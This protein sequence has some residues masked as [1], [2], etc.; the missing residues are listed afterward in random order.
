ML[1]WLLN[2]FKHD[3]IKPNKA[4]LTQGR[5]RKQGLNSAPVSS[6]PGAPPAQRN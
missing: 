6:R 2:L 5:V 3:S 4:L 1:K